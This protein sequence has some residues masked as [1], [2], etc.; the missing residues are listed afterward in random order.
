MNKTAFHILLLR[1]G[2]TTA[3]REKR[4]AG[5]T[6]VSLSDEGIAALRAL[7]A[8]G[9]Y[10]DSSGYALYTSNLLRAK[11]TLAVLFPGSAAAALSAFN[12]MDFGAFEMHSYEELKDRAE[13]RLWI[14]D[15]TGDVGCPMGESANHFRRRVMEGMGKLMAKREDALVVT[16]GGV[17]AQ[18]MQALFPYESRHFYQWQPENGCGYLIRFSG[19]AAA[20]YRPIHIVNDRKEASL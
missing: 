3:N 9:L 18:I 12:E 17:I 8:S 1:H 10:P 5:S 4:Y 13:Y 7:K 19:S 15:T 14:E 11:E 20:S 16:H 2:A 6:D